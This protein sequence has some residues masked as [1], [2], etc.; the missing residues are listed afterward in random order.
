MPE[1]VTEGI[2][3][4]IVPGPIYKT[5]AAIDHGNSGGIAILNKNDCSLGIP[6][7]GVSGL[8]AGIGYIQSYSLASQPIIYSQPSVA[9]STPPAPAN[10]RQFTVFGQGFCADTGGATLTIGGTWVPDKYILSWTDNSITFVV[11]D[12]IA[13]GN[14]DVQILGARGTAYCPAAS[15]GRINVP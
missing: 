9:P 6:T 3:S 4:G 14:Y 12:S 11:P 15:G 13:R 5:N 8:T 1:T 2:V 7:L 10:P